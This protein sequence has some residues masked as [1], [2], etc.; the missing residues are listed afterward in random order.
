[1]DNA[2]EASDSE[3]V[4]FEH[5]FT[6]MLSGSR[7]GGVNSVINGLG[8]AVSATQFDRTV[9]YFYGGQIQNQK[10]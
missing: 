7:G 8:G 10:P 2:I 4:Y 5:I 3:D 9:T 1:M 6:V